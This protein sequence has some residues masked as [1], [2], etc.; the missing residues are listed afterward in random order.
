MQPRTP[1]GRSVLGMSDMTAEQRRLLPLIF[2]VTLTSIMGNALLSPAIPDILDT[3]G[4]PQSTAGLLV[5]ATA[6][7]GIVVAP[8]VGLLADR[9]G[10]RNVLVPCLAIFGVAGLFV[11]I[12]PTFNVM[13]LAR[14]A[15]G[16]GAAGLVNLAIVLIGD[17]FPADRQAYWIGKNSGVLT[18]ALATF[19]LVSGIVT[20]H[21][22]WRWAL[23]PCG[24][25]IVTAG[26]AWFM[27][28]PGRPT[29]TITVR[30]QLGGVGEALRNRTILGT[31]V[32][33]GLAFA[34]I[35][36]VFLAVLPNHLESEFGL[37]AGWRGLVIGLPAITSS[38]SAFN[39]DWIR[40]RI[41][42]GPLLIASAA[43]WVGAFALMGL[44]AALTVLIVGT[45][46][47]GLAE[48][49]MIPALQT[50]AMS[51]AP[52]QHRAAV[53]ATWT[54]FARLGQTSGPLA[55]GLILSAGGTTWALLSG[56]IAAA[57]LMAIFSL[58]AIRHA[59]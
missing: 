11:A 3:F 14:F 47:Y 9:L 2:A 40:R 56:A 5:A 44:A 32:G 58:T 53:M 18:A 57:G 28:E 13:L 7:P 42:I 22:G 35:F 16:F 23:A 25:G 12:A 52:Q 8:I 30:A 20:D 34:M 46:V 1:G 38:L 43:L 49:A 26:V 17:T 39:L 4:K 50:T 59:R 41:P 10:R 33:G 48:G 55:A 31:L 45:L 29:E 27:L 51:N 24:L 37:S 15:M 21:F 36:G 54:G 19:P 6:L